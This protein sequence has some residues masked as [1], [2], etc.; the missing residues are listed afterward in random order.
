MRFAAEA[1]PRDFARLA[2]AIVAHA[3]S[4]DAI[5][6]ELMQLAAGHIDG[7][8]RRLVALGAPRLSLLGGLAE[9]IS[10]WLADATRRLLSPPRGDALTGALALARAEAAALRL[11][12]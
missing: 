4:G 11:S 1:R 9:P 10:A 7:L 2:P 12:A 5:A 6:C 8:A 3:R